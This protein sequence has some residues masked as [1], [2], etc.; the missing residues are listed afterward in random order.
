ML[1]VTLAC[2]WNPAKLID[3]LGNVIVRRSFFSVRIPTVPI[4]AT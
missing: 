4:T 1:H 2:P 3:L